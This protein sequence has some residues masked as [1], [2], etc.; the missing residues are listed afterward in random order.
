MRVAIVTMVGYFNYGNRLQSYALQEALSTAASAVITI[1]N[2]LPVPV[3]TSAGRLQRLLAN[4]ILAAK[5]KANALWET[6]HPRRKRLSSLRYESFRRF[7]N[8]YISESSYMVTEQDIS[9]FPEQE[10]D[11]V[12]VGSD[13]IWNPDGRR[14]NPIDFLRFVP[15]EKRIAYAPSLAVSVL[16]E[17][18][19]ELYREWIDD[20]PHLSC[21]EHRGAEIIKELTGRHAEVVLDPTMLLSV[22]KWDALRTP[23]VHRPKKPFLVSYFLGEQSTENKRAIASY[24]KKRNLDVI[25]L[26]DISHPAYT[27]GPAEFVDFIAASDGVLTDSFHGAVFAILYKKPF[28]TIDRVGGPQMS[29]RMDTLLSTFN[30]PQQ[31]VVGNLSANFAIETDYAHVDSILEA[32]RDRSTRYLSGALADVARK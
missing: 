30:L 19:R 15:R 9:Q 20:F 2:D 17:E 8:I 14:G 11:A 28:L 4:P 10:F 25:R 29:S 3:V 24:A 6:H 1:R 12:V 26:G 16:P 31:R 23:S 21:R 13:Q 27:D 32:E 22:E 18:Y 7:T 5:S